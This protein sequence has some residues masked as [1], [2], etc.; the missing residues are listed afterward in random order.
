[1]AWLGIR[2]RGLAPGT[3]TRVLGLVGRLLPDAPGREGARTADGREA[4][5]RLGSSFVD[6][7]T[8]LGERAARRNLG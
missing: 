1:L 2:V 8:T 3:T 7:L 6:R 4:A 5:R